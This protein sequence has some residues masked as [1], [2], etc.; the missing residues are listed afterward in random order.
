MLHQQ[1]QLLTL[2]VMATLCFA[3]RL[4]AQENTN[5]SPWTIGLEIATGQHL[6]SDSLN[7]LWD[8][9][10]TYGRLGAEG[11]YRFTRWLA[12]SGQMQFHRSAITDQI[13][14]FSSFNSGNSSYH[15][16]Q[17]QNLLSLSIGPEL[18]LR[19][20]Q[21][22]F[23]LFFNYGLAA[24]FSKVR[25]V[26]QDGT[27]F[28]VNYKPAVVAIQQAGFGYTYWPTPKL[29][30][31]ASLSWQNTELGNRTFDQLSP[32]SIESTPATS[33]DNLEPIHPRGNRITKTLI[34]GLGIH[35]RFTK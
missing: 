2:L 21:G 25:A 18:M 28:I 30:V 20:G 7:V 1:N 9:F 29:G 11:G 22:D 26:R 33:L 23:R 19:V 4:Q 17:T 32:R 16:H 3:G 24:N 27:V 5:L 10:S 14:S 12:I 35:Y 15:H 6:T 13:I 8:D 34:F 31:S